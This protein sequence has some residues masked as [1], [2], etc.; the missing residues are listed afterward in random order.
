MT[1]YFTNITVI[2]SKA[3]AHLM[4]RLLSAIDDCKCKHCSAE[5]VYDVTG[6]STANVKTD[7]EYKEQIRELENEKAKLEHSYKTEM[8]TLQDEIVQ[9]KKDLEEEKKKSRV[10]QQELS[11]YSLDINS[12]FVAKYENQMNQH[13]GYFNNEVKKWNAPKFNSLSQLALHS[14]LEISHHNQSFT[15]SCVEFFDEFERISEKWDV[16]TEGDRKSKL[17]LLPN[18][19]NMHAYCET[20][21]SLL[22]KLLTNIPETVFSQYYA[23][24]RGIDTTNPGDYF[25]ELNDNFHYTN[26]TRPQFG[27]KRLSTFL[28]FPS[29][30]PSNDSQI[31]PDSDCD[32]I[33]D[34][35]D[36]LQNSHLVSNGFLNSKKDALDPIELPTKF[37]D[38]P[39]LPLNGNGF[40]SNTPSYAKALAKEVPK[41]VAKPDNRNNVSTNTKELIAK[42]SNDIVTNSGLVVKTKKE[43]YYALVNSL[44][45]NYFHD[46]DDITIDKYLEIV[47]HE[48]NFTLHGLQFLEIVRRI[49]NIRERYNVIVGTKPKQ[50]VKNKETTKKKTNVA[51]LEVY[52]LDEILYLF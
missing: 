50:V 23:R 16:K 17:P 15:N 49:K 2:E 48:N 52:K 28:Q 26:I 47:R 34:Y 36:E 21:S 3:F 37:T 1:E 8:Q 7:N 42:N 41:P 9:L 40:I 14:K 11:L 43:K 22:S 25:S 38:L 24:I 31:S 5:I 27:E 20:I 46:L 29:K 45:I 30:E 35:D 12:T 13:V 18:P 32:D 4:L 51:G 6:E 19:P 33:L 10:L 44:K 39:F